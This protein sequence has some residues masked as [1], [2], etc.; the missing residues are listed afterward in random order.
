MVLR[1]EASGRWLDYKREG[2]SWMGLEPL[3]R[4]SRELLSSFYWDDRGW[5]GWMASLTWWA[6]VWANSRRW[7]WTG[8]PGVLRFMGSQRVGH[9]WVTELNWTEGYNEKWSCA[10]KKRTLNRTQLWSE[11]ILIL[12]LQPPEPWEINFCCLLPTQSVAS[13]YSSPNQ[14]DTLMPTVAIYAGK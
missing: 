6:W 14:L 12:D 2:A 10:T 5:D 1:D 8:R 3:Q 4:D 11:P 7:W 13:F 9:D